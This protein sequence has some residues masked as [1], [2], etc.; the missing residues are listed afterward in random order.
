MVAG[1]VVRRGHGMRRRGRRQRGSTCF[2]V[3][4]GGQRRVPPQWS[5]P[6]GPSCWSGCSFVEG[7]VGGARGRQKMDNGRDFA[8][9][10][11]RM[12]FLL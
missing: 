12:R 8:S 2:W 6:V 1:G 4:A 7:A 11:A 3:M 9:F 5:D 10:L